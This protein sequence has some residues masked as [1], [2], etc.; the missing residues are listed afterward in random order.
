MNEKKES[1]SHQCLTPWFPRT[2][3]LQCDSSLNHSTEFSAGLPPTASPLLPDSSGLA[4]TC[5][6]REASRFQTGPKTVA[7]SPKVLSNQDWPLS[8]PPP[9]QSSPRT[10]PRPRL[11]KTRM[12]SRIPSMGVSEPVHPRCEQ[13]R[14][15]P[16]L[17][18]TLLGHSQPRR[19]PPL[20][21]SSWTSREARSRSARSLSSTWQATSPLKHSSASCVVSSAIWRGE[22]RQS[23]LSGLPTVLPPPMLRG[24]ILTLI[25]GLITRQACS[26]IR[27]LTARVSGC[28]W[29][30]WARIPGP[31]LTLCG[32]EPHRMP[33]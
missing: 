3:L 23:Y 4:H 19:S 8:P 16:S 1:F 17:P 15:G 9:P 14:A 22:L 20:T 31:A 24:T 27:W 21:F 12:S 25:P 29:S 26:V 10:P 33:L 11:R 6:G 28:Y 7:I 2:H 13:R 32:S 30:W 18:A 5:S